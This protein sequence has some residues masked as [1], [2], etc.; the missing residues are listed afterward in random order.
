MTKALTL[1]APEIAPMLALGVQL[2]LDHHLRGDACVIGA[3][4]PQRVESIHAVLTR[5]R[6]HQ[7]VLKGVPHVQRAGD[8]RRRDDDR[9]RLAAAGRREPA[10]RLPALVETLLDFPRVV[11]LFHGKP[12]QGGA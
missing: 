4:L 3:G 12:G 7:R 11:S 9:I 6:I 5:E 10:V 1:I 8:V 2:P